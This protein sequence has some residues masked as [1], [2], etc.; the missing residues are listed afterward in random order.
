M[1]QARLQTFFFT[2][3]G[4]RLRP[5]NFVLRYFTHTHELSF[6][7]HTASRIPTKK[8]N[9]RFFEIESY[10]HRRTDG[11]FFLADLLPIFLLSFDIFSVLAVVVPLSFM[12]AF[13]FFGSSLAKGDTGVHH[14][15]SPSSPQRFISLRDSLY[16]KKIW[17]SANGNTGKACALCGSEHCTLVYNLNFFPFRVFCPLINVVVHLLMLLARSAPGQLQTRPCYHPWMYRKHVYSKCDEYEPK[18]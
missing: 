10:V 1:A 7:N 3:H 2:T 11:C 6:E 5:L 9:W 13:F 16:W 8:R 12:C 4:N 14:A 15:G 18:L 17:T